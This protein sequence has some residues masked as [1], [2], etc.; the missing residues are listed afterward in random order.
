[1]DD[2][3]LVPKPE[4]SPNFT[5]AVLAYGCPLSGVACVARSHFIGIFCKAPHSDLKPPKFLLTKH[6]ERG[7]PQNPI[8]G[9]WHK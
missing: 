4:Q 9:F 8:N 6:T 3:H 2:G 7:G 1:M 5:W